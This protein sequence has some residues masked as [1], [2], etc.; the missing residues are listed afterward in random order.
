MV[1]DK[2]PE[3]LLEN[4]GIYAEVTMA[5]MKR[6]SHKDMHEKALEKAKKYIAEE[7]YVDAK[8]EI[9]RVLD[10][11]PT[12]DR[13]LNLL[14]IIMLK[15][16]QY[17]KAVKIYEELITRY[18]QTVS[19]RTNL[20]VAY[21][22][23]NQHDSA[24]KEFSLVLQKD[25]E[26]KTI[27]KLYGKALLQL[28]RTDEAIEMFKKAGMDEYVKK[29]KKG[30]SNEA[31]ESELS[32][33]DI[34]QEAMEKDKAAEPHEKI[35]VPSFIPQQETHEPQPEAPVDGNGEEAAVEQQ[36]AGHAGVEEYEE[37]QTIETERGPSATDEQ[38]LMNEQTEVPEGPVTEEPEK[39][40]TVQ[41]DEPAAATQHFS[42]EGHSVPSETKED[43]SEKAGNQDVQQEE[44]NADTKSPEGLSLLTEATSLSKFG[45]AVNFINDAM[46]LF[47]LN[48][49][50]VY[51][52]DKGIVSLTE[53]L[54]IEQAY[55]R[56]RGKDTKSVFA[57][58]KD[59]PIVL[60][61]G[62]GALVL[63]SDY[64]NIKEFN[65]KN[66]SMFLDDER[67]I[68]FQGDLEW[69]NGR[70]EVQADKSINVTQIRGTADVFVGLHD[71]L[72]SIHV[73]AEHYLSVRLNSLIGWYGKLIPRQSSIKHYNNDSFI[74][75]HGEGVVFIDA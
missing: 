57:E 17:A 25:P 5:K 1:C 9:E 22:K 24:I 29:I 68:A 38:E 61:Y 73:H 34:M 74:S 70:V 32:T 65:L 47:N 18:P 26:S 3:G 35:A 66:E 36:A 62:K 41:P 30:G 63:K 48:G 67:L 50:I 58:K 59:D 51:V 45:S 20:G 21:L 60:V 55:K 23:N 19:L 31:V 13:A 53:S 4:E 27:L 14:A 11:S 6:L 49:N 10:F 64:K 75:F 7:N 12:D 39:E 54:T 46:V 44:E 42:G 37:E 2:G 28:S 52:R 33:E 8:D 71:Q 15:L 40:V 72:Q 16:E 43:R 56:Y 69:E